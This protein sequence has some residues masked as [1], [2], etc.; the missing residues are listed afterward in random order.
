MEEESQKCSFAGFVHVYS[1][2]LNEVKFMH[3]NFKGKFYAPVFSGFI[4]F[5]YKVNVFKVN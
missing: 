5:T 3:H 1:V 2:W 4:G